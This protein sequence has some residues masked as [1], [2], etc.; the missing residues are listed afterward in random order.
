MLI[1]VAPWP[2]VTQGANRGC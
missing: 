1:T 2:L